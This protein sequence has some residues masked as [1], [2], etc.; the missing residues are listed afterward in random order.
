MFLNEREKQIFQTNAVT[1]FSIKL[2]AH[3]LNISRLSTPIAFILQS[4]QDNIKDSIINM[5]LP[6]QFYYAEVNNIQL[7]CNMIISLSVDHI[8]DMLASENS[9][10]T[11]H[12]YLKIGQSPTTRDFD[13]H[14]EFKLSGLSAGNKSRTN[15]IRSKFDFHEG[16]IFRKLDQGSIMLTNLSLFSTNGSS[17]D[18]SNASTMR[19]IRA[20]RSI[21]YAFMYEGSLPPVRYISNDYTYDTVGERTKFP[22]K[23]RSYCAECRYWN[24]TGSKWQTDGIEVSTINCCFFLRLILLTLAIK[25]HRRKVMFNV[26]IL[27]Y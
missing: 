24:E 18:G 11:L 21:H 6:D 9:N 27:F 26:Y 19:D 1:S 23:L 16:N 3:K 10:I 22:L 2:D 4:S 20:N 14:Q 8:L 25:F 13:L 7:S 15:F 17:L 5:S 12:F